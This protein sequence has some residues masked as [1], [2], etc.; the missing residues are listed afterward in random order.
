MTPAADLALW[1]RWAFVLT[2][3]NTGDTPFP[4]V[5]IPCEIHALVRSWPSMHEYPLYDY[6][7]THI[8]ST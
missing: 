2:F 4:M 5:V 8:A 1:Q 3:L 7:Y 6:V